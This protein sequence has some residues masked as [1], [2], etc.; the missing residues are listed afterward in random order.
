MLDPSTAPDPLLGFPDPPRDRFEFWVRF[1]LG[2]ILG[3]ILGRAL[4]LRYFWRIDY[5]WLLIPALGCMFAF[6]GGAFRRQLLGSTARLEMAA[7]V[8]SA[9]VSI[10]TII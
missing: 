4:W 8:V 10:D 2:A 1:F 5:G 7:L 9:L 3:I 6:A